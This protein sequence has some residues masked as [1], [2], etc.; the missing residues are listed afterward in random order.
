MICILLVIIGW[1]LNAIAVELD[2]R[3]YKDYSYILIALAFIPYI[4]AILY[5]PVEFTEFLNAR[6]NKNEKSK[7]NDF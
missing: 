4:A 6:S 1:S 7:R 5:I 2:A 3:R